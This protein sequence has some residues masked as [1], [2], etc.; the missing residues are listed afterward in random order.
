MLKLS[1]KAMAT[2]NAGEAITYTDTYANSGGGAAS[3]VTIAVIV[4][5]G[6]CY[7][8]ALDLG[9][10]SR[11][12]SVT[13]NGD[14]TRTLM[15]NIGSVAATSGDQTIVFTARSTL[16]ALAGTTYTQSVTASYKNAGGA[17][18]FAPVTSSD[19]TTITVVPPSRSPLSQGFWKNHP[20]LWTAEFLARIQATDQRYDAN[21]NGALSAAEAKA[22]FT[23]N[24]APKTVLNVQLLGT[25]FNLAGRRINA[26]TSISSIT[27]K[28]LGLSNV[29][30]AALYAQRTLTLPVNS[31]TSPRYN[32]IIGVLD[33]INANTIEVY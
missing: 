16:L 8:P 5:A 32:D 29:R 9:A 27:S 28:S 31:S 33:N 20:E 22:G 12:S 23:T 10:G 24:T 21:A 25:Y 6:V 3:N 4:P 14:G 19:T 13:L 11:P 26:G 17:C 15:W 7:S 18:T 2:A 30:D 1:S